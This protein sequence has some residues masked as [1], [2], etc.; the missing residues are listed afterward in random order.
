M[1]GTQGRALVDML[2]TNVSQKLQVQNCVADQILP[3]LNVVQQSG[4]IGKYGKEHLRIVNTIAGGKGHI[5]R[6]DTVTRS[7]DSYYIDDH[8]L[9]DVVTPNDY[10]N[11]IDPFDAE[12]DVVNGLT[13]ILQLDKELGLANSLTDTAVLTQNTT[14]TGS[15]QW[16]DYA[17]SD[18]VAN[19]NTAK[20]TIRDGCGMVSDLIAIC[21]WKVAN[22]LRFHPAILAAL[23]YAYN[24]A[25]QLTNEELAKVFEVK[26]FLVPDAVYLSSNEG[27]SD[28]LAPV[29]GKH[30]V[31]AQC[32]EK[33]AKMQISLGYRVQYANEGPRKVYKY[34][35]NNPPGSNA[36]ICKD[37]YDQLITA[38]GAGYLIKNCIA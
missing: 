4:K 33:A 37:D 34:V 27:Q 25:G 22:K 32:P 19:I 11:V 28:V 16:S 31:L 35:I 18:P 36:I 2:L 14:L 26:R 8:G 24:R 7:S 3:E 23:G 38:T 5:R 21:D 29:W 6:V 30:F 13:S 12:A 10:R 20:E 15:G 17:N 9:E 1:S